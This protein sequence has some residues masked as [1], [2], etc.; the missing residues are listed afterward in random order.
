[1]KRVNTVP[2]EV[3]KRARELGDIEHKKHPNP[4]V[5]LR[6]MREYSC[7]LALEAILEALNEAKLVAPRTER[8]K[9]MFEIEDL[10]R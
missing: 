7:G 6:Q 3:K 9:L 4:H 8:I 10:Y 1:M 5:H 2:E